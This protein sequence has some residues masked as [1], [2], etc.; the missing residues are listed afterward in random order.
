MYKFSSGVL[1]VTEVSEN[2]VVVIDPCQHGSVNTVVVSPLY[3]LGWR[4][5]RQFNSGYPVML[6]W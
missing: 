4:R 5:F 6:M 1:Q 2:L 3:P